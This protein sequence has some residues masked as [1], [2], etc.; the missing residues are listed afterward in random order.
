LTQQP[1]PGK[2]RYKAIADDLRAAINEGTLAAGAKLMS[3]TELM[4][5][6]DVSRGTAREA[7]GVLRAEGLVEAR[8]G[9]GVYVRG[10][11]KITRNATERLASNVWGVGRPI[12]SVDL[13]ARPMTT[14]NL[15]VEEITPPERIAAC[16][17]LQP[18]ETV[19]MRDR[20]YLVEG[21]AVQRATSYLP[22]SIVAG[23][24]I[25]QPNSGPGGTYAR[26]AELGHAPA[27]FREE[28][29][30]RMPLAEEATR[31]GL[32]AGTPVLL[33]ARTAFDKDNRPVE[34]NEMMLDASSYVLQYDFQA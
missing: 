3:E 17:G 24:A 29:Q 34:V 1:Q 13:D 4:A 30:T 26:L 11:R 15:R 8:R 16:F 12:W 7:L 23:S 25:T 33:I 27:K 21:R 6:Y 20:D 5:E 22:A 18:G 10:F 19:W 31:L 2:P 28:L 14:A 32:S 9:A